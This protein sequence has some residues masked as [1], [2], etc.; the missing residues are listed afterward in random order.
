VDSTTTVTH[1]PAPTDMTRSPGRNAATSPGTGRFRPGSPPS[2]P[3]WLDP[4]AHPRP[5]WSIAT[6]WLF[7]AATCTIFTPG[8]NPTTR[9]GWNR[10]LNVPSPSWPSELEPHVHTSPWSVS[11]AACAAPAATW[12]A[13]APWGQDLSTLPARDRFPSAFPSPSAPSWLAPHAHT[14]PSESA[15]T[16]NPSPAATMIRRVP[17]GRPVTSTGASRWS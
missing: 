16:V 7:P 4:Q 15:A 8:G 13:L 2:A 10:S 14:R 1:Q 3:S 17:S 12:T 9:T 6:V 11:T 5:H